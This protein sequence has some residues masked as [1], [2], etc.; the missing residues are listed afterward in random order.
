[1]NVIEKAL[2]IASKAHANQFRKHTDIPYI[3]HP[4]AVGMMLMKAGYGDDLVAAGILHD[5][6]ED[7]SLTLADIERDFGRIIARI[8]EGCSEPDKSLSWEERKKHTI[9]FL[10][11]APEE[12]RAVACADKL[13]NIQSIIE[14]YKLIGESVWERF[15]RGKGDQE[16]YYRNVVESLGYQT[17]IRLLDELKNEVDQLFKPN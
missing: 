5:T 17:N 11:T 10:K 14:D 4:V 16:W 15:N 3:T 1:M 9:E 12:V 8:V 7:T 2:Q 13:H 6:V